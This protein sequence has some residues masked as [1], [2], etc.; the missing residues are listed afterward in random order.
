MKKLLLTIMLVCLT[1][2]VFAQN[3]DRQYETNGNFSI[4][5]PKGWSVA[6]LP[7]WKY[8]IYYDRPI[9]NFSPNIAIVDEYFEG[10]LDEYIRLSD[11]NMQILY[12]DA[13][14]INNAPFR[15]NGGL[16]GRKQIL[17]TAN[18]GRLLKQIFYAY[19]NGSMKFVITCTV[20]NGVSQNYEKIFDESVKTF[21]FIIERSN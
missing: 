3:G 17:L 16:N 1:L 15:T 21:E 20:P 12:P 6:E 4:C 19:S 11:Q 5:P 7:G 9:N 8:K 18:S 2:P 14:L 13:E 10:S